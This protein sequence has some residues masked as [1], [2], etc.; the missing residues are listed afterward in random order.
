MSEEL[1]P[2][3][4]AGDAAMLELGVIL[5]QGH[6]FG[7]IAGRCSAA[8]AEAIRHLREEKIYLQCCETWEEF[9]PQYLKMCRTEAD[10]AIR[11][12]EEFGP[13]YFELSQ[14][15]RVS[16]RTYRAI[17]PAIENGV[18]R[19]NGEEIPL[20]R[21]N[22]RKVAEAVAQ[23]RDALGKKSSEEQPG[24]QPELHQRLLKAERRGLALVREFDQIAAEAGAGS[25]R[26]ALKSALMRVRNE[27]TRIAIDVAKE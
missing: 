7:V 21:D 25:T 2:K 16:P 12:L 22:S 4:A 27:L 24:G 10:R 8:Q 26:L 17:A 14:L 11:L 15:T 6:A 1:L 13:A 20:N 3:R 18:L 23:M 9:C 19:F 5:G